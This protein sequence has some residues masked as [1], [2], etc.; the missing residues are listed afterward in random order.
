MM[1]TLLKNQ[2]ETRL[3]SLAAPDPSKTR[4]VLK[5]IPLEAVDPEAA[6]SFSLEKVLE[7]QAVLKQP[8]VRNGKQATVGYRP[9]VWKEWK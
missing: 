8:I 2:I 9:E 7:N 5:G 1:N 6:A 3:Q 4:V